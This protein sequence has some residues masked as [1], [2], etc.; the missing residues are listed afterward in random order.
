MRSLGN[1]EIEKGEKYHRAVVFFGGE[2]ML[3]W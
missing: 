3:L 2:L 1:C